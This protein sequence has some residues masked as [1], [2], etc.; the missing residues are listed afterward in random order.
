MCVCVCVC[1][2]VRVYVHLRARVLRVSVCIYKYRCEINVPK[3][4]ADAARLDAMSQTDVRILYILSLCT[5]L[6]CEQNGCI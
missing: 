1:V 6:F 2:R 5:Y 3:W 4:S